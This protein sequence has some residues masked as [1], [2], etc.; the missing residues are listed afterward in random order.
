M[1]GTDDVIRR[2]EEHIIDAHLFRLRKGRI[3]D[4]TAVQVFCEGV[5]AS[6]KLK[7]LE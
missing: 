1:G 4:D 6:Q 7:R 2:S 3:L 5:V